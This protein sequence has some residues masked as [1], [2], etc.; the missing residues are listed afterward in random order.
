[1]TKELNHRNETL[2][3][4]IKIFL[5]VCDPCRQKEKLTRKT[6]WLNPWYFH[7]RTQEVRQ[8]LEF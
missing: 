3:N 4:D 5:Y 7:I 8:T 6:L 1:M 2:E